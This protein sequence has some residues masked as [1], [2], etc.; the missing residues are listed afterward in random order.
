LL[1]QYHQHY[2]PR[3]EFRADPASHNLRNVNVSIYSDDGLLTPPGWKVN[4]E[5]DRFGRD[6]GVIARGP[7]PSHDDRMVAIIA[8]RSSLGT[9]AACR[10]F[11]DVGVITEIRNRLAAMKI[12]MENHK[13]AFWAVVSIQCSRPHRREAM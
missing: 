7:N 6:F 4:A 13:D 2:V 5:N 11:T 1:E 9:E 8:G 12:E 3:I 10:A